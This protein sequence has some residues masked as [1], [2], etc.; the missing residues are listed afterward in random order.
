MR[1]LLDTHV[2]LWWLTNDPSLTQDHRKIIMHKQNRC[3]VSAA[4]VWEMSIKAGLG[5]LEIPKDYL[6]VVRSQGFFELP[7]TWAH[8]EVARQLPTHHKDPFDRLL[9]SQT[10]SEGMTLLTVDENIKKYGISVT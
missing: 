7:I 10:I 1:Y 6:D 8:A 3:F 5:K 9:I 2:I 4:T